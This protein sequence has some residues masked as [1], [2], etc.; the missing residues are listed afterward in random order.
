MFGYALLFLWQSPYYYRN[1]LIFI[2]SMVTRH[3]HDHHGNEVFPWLLGNQGISMV[4]MATKESPWKIWQLRYLKS[5]HC[6]QSIPRVSLWLLWQR[7]YL[8]F[9]H[10]YHGNQ[11]I[12]GVSVVAMEIKVSMVFVWFPCNRY[13][14]YLCGCH[15]HQ[16]IHW[17]ILNKY[18]FW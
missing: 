15:G 4:S 12:Q 11:G 8:R 3:L 18:Y 14:K 17:T 9:L 13:P 2:V 7:T 16:G 10:G 5:C 1:N 6:N